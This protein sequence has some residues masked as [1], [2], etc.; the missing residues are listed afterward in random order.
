MNKGCRDAQMAVFFFFH[1]AGG[2]SG[3][4]ANALLVVGGASVG[5]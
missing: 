1:E 2:R 4:G 5:G 3:D